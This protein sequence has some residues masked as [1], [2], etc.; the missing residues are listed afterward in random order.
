ME[1]L[2][3][4]LQE[5]LD[6]DGPLDPLVDFRLSIGGQPEA[7]DDR[8]AKF[9]DDWDIGLPQFGVNPAILLPGAS[10]LQDI[11][12]NEPDAPHDLEIEPGFVPASMLFPSDTGPMFLPADPSYQLYDG[13]IYGESFLEQPRPMPGS[14]ENSLAI[15]PQ[16]G[17]SG[18]SEYDSFRDLLGTTEAN[19]YTIPSVVGDYSLIGISARPVAPIS[20]LD[21]AGNLA[22]AIIIASP[23]VRNRRV[24][25]TSNL[26]PI[27][28]LRSKINKSKGKV[29]TPLTDGRNQYRAMDRVPLA[30]MSGNSAG[31]D[32]DDGI[33]LEKIAG[34]GKGSLSMP[35]AFAQSVGF[36]QQPDPETNIDEGHFDSDDTIDLAEYAAA[37]HTYGNN[38]KGGFCRLDS[39]LGDERAASLERSLDITNGDYSLLQQTSEES[40]DVTVSAAT[41]PAKRG[42]GRPIVPGSKRQRRIQAMA[43]PDYVPPKR[44]RP[45]TNENGQR[46]RVRRPKATQQVLGQSF[47]PLPIYVSPA[48]TQFVP[49]AS[50]QEVDEQT[51]NQMYKPVVLNNEIGYTP[52]QFILD[53]AQAGKIQQIYNVELPPGGWAE[54]IERWRLTFNLNRITPSSEYLYHELN[55]LVEKTPGVAG[56]NSSKENIEPDSED[57]NNRIPTD[58]SINNIQLTLQ[59]LPPQEVRMETASQN[60]FPDHRLQIVASDGT[61]H[62]MTHEQVLEKLLDERDVYFRTIVWE[63]MQKSQRIDSMKFIGSWNRMS[64]AWGFV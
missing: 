24:L 38:A 45:R 36:R 49:E 48:A 7:D 44:G 5:I 39:L 57:A 43:Q 3:D 18:S 8:G 46:K 63:L 1:N 64:G 32:L 4:D 16:L 35:Q 10:G 29:K 13:D 55:K 53:S 40:P 59:T 19:T 17:D 25:K 21:T 41:V 31:S 42:R 52:D 15:D 51:F 27:D 33:D 14:N 47:S 20:P 54:T 30:E 11:Y 2:N 56:S 61:Y 22:P 9:F 34:I 60:L 62:D 12:D 26:N 37:C 58:E 50:S 28:T 6:T 23:K